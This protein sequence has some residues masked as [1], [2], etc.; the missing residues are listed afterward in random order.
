MTKF[1]INKIPPVPKPPAKE[2]FYFNL[3]LAKEG[4]E[5]SG[6][7]L[8]VSTIS[9]HNM[10]LLMINEDGKL[11]L[12]GYGVELEDCAAQSFFRDNFVT[13]FNKKANA[14]VL[15]PHGWERKSIV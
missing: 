8:I 7:R 9:G 14:R 1:H 6:V 11:L 3:E 10:C 4:E 13:A 12:N 2:E 15:I 5:Y